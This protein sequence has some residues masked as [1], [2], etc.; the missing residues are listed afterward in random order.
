M[1]GVLVVWGV[2]FGVGCE[3]ECKN[4]ART[5][6]RVK[7]QANE[8]RGPAVQCN[9]VEVCDFGHGRPIKRIPLSS[10][11]D[12]QI[13]DRGSASDNRDSCISKARDKKDITWN[14]DCK[15]EASPELI[16]LDAPSPSNGPDF[17]GSTGGTFVT[18]GVG[19]GSGDYWFDEQGAGGAGSVWADPGAGGQGGI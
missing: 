18:V 13:V 1:V 10:L 5:W 4:P 7:G 16:C 3:K 15:L 2:L 8:I 6:D 12:P 14:P 17:T 11:L 9:I 19:A